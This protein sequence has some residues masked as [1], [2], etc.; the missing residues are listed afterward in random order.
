MN[1]YIYGNEKDIKNKKEDFRNYFVKVSIISEKNFQ[2]LFKDKKEKVIALDPDIVDWAFPNEIIDKIPNLKAIC[3][4]TT[5]YEWVD[6]KHCAK[7]N[8]MVT[9]VPGYATN[10]VAEQCIFMALAL[11][12]KFALFE[13]E[14][15]MNY[16]PE[17]IGGDM[18][19]K[20][21]GIVGLGAIGSRVAE[22]CKG[23]GL[24]V[25]YFSRNPK[26]S[27]YKYVSIEELLK[28]CDYIFFTI[29]K[30]PDSEKLLNKER[31]RLINKNANVVTIVNGDLIDSDYLCKRVEKGTLSGF[32]FESKDSN[33]NHY[34]GNVFVTPFCA[35]YTKK[36]LK[37]MYEIW[38]DTIISMIS[39]T[40][41]N[42]V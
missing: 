10:S 27:K 42:R 37:N 11:T 15:K 36:S 35:W 41:K 31:L 4:L 22:M 26:K 32:A 8:I 17:F 24:D 39:D 1:L 9:N 14:G 2:V 12:K 30:N 23:L 19:G 40:P 5:G 3:L 7:K 29:S 25:L 13:K 6:I 28:E 20:K 21:A 18:A 34:K 38:F 33:L 16:S